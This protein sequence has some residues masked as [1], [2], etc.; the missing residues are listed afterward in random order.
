MEARRGCLIYWC[1]SCWCTSLLLSV[2]E[3]KWNMRAE[4]PGPNHI[5]NFLDVAL[6]CR[7]PA[8]SL[9]PFFHFLVSVVLFFS[10]FAI[11]SKG[12][13]QSLLSSTLQTCIGY[14]EWLLFYS[15]F[16]YMPFLYNCWVFVNKSNSGV[17]QLLFILEACPGF[18]STNTPPFQSLYN[19]KTVGNTT[20]YCAG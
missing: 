8:L 2:R 9:S 17:E 12:D 20:K 14:S 7:S 1:F 4:T 10:L 15:Y 19:M 3:G 18:K 13:L 16:N 5:F 11:C 6:A